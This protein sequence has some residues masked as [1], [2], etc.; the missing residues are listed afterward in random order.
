V[1][2]TTL[3]PNGYGIVKNN[4]YNVPAIFPNAWLYPH[5]GP[6]NTFQYFIEG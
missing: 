5:P 6:T 1:I 2:G 4:F 3:P